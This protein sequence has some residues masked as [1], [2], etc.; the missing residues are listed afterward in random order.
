VIVDGV[1]RGKTMGWDATIIDLW[2]RGFP[3]IFWSGRRG[4]ASDRGPLVSCDVVGNVIFTPVEAL[5]TTW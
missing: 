2:V 1:N 5:T 4:T 3:R